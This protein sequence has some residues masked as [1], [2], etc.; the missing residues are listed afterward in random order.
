VLCCDVTPARVTD[1]D[2]S[3]GMKESHCCVTIS[4]LM[5]LRGGD[6]FT[7]KPASSLQSARPRA[8]DNKRDLP[9]LRVFLLHSSHTNERNF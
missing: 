1:Q 2:V 5:I 7:F 9:D 3:V 8:I 6:D 4:Y